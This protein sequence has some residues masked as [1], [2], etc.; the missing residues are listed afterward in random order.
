M[1]AALGWVGKAKG[2]SSK[3]GEVRVTVDG[4]GE[5]GAALGGES[6]LTV[7]NET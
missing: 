6:E 5:V 4:V 3:L 7:C 1:G 2:V